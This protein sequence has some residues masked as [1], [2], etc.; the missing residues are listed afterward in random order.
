MKARY[1]SS[2]MGRFT[3]VDPSGK[4][5]IPT[6]PQ[7]WNRYAYCYNNPLALVDKNG[8]WPERTHN[9]IIRRAFNALNPG[10]REQIQRGS[11]SVDADFKN[12]RKLA[13][14]NTLVES[15]APRHAMT[16]GFKVR[17]LG[18]E[19]AAREWARNEASIFINDRMGKAQELYG[20][21][22]EATTF[23]GKDALRAAAYRAFGEGAHTIMDGSS[24]AH[25]DFQ[26]YDT[27]QYDRGIT[28]PGQSILGF[29]LGMQEHG[30][31][32][33]RRPTDEEMTGMVDTLRLRYYRAFGADAYN[34]AVSPE[35][36]KLT[37]ERLGQRGIRF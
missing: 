17:E 18:S 28:N 26:V 24:P 21:S 7:T 32:E 12:P 19:S 35:E 33:S 3:G 16:P 20:Q 15:M 2:T 25:R 9:E 22:R 30:N 10:K 31:E 23:F 34:E 37:A 8:K 5:I 13:T 4:S 11:A 27:A 29:G 36:R 14:E 1:Y 6:N